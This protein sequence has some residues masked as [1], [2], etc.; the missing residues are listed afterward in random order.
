VLGIEKWKFKEGEG[1]SFEKL[2]MKLGSMKGQ[3]HSRTGGQSNS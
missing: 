2:D 1:Y 3:G